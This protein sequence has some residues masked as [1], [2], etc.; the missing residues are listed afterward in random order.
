[1]KRIEKDYN[2]LMA[3]IPE[4]PLTIH[5]ASFLPVHES[6]SHTVVEKKHIFG[7]GNL[8]VT[9]QSPPKQEEKVATNAGTRCCWE[10]SGVRSC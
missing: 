2:S 5:A 4:T 1:M 7:R 3:Q 10:K 8:T 6:I 9:F